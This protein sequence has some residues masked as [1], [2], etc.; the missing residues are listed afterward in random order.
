M[1][2]ILFNWWRSQQFKAALNQKDQ[3]RAINILMKIQSS[4]AKLSVLEK[5]FQENLKIQK[6]LE[7]E[8]KNVKNIKQYYTHAK[9]KI[10]D[11][12]EIIQFFEFRETDHSLKPQE[13]L[14]QFIEQTFKLIKHDNYKLQC[15]GIDENIFNEFEASLVACLQEIFYSID[16]NLLKQGLKEAQEDIERLKRGQDPIYRFNFTP[17][18]YFMRY[19]LDN[20]YCLYLAWFLIYKSGLLTTKVNILDIAAGPGTVAYGLALFLK[21]SQNF[22]STQ[23]FHISYYSLEQLDLFQLRG[24]QFWRQYMEPQH[25]AVNAYFR[26]NTTDIFDYDAAS[27]KIPQDFFDFVVI[28][29]CTFNN[30]DQRKHAHQIYRKIVERSLK[31]Q[32]YILIIVQNKKIYM[33]YNKKPSEDIRQEKQLIETFLAEINLKLIWYQYLTSTGK[34]TPLGSDFHKFAQENLPPKKYMSPLMMQYL[35]IKHHSN[36]TLDDYVILAQ[37]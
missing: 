14:I 13:N 12:E 21:S 32:G 33:P 35:D 25:N 27:P 5:L 26:F 11:L 17:Y 7:K 2:N 8:Q 24:L 9:K 6:K 23:K 19:F 28:S 29:H 22:L 30:P 20:V 16:S 10:E 18:V 15:T 3:Q 4:G 34:R 31:K 36:Y 1:S 37:K